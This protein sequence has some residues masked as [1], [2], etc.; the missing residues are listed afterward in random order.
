LRRPAALWH[1]YWCGGTTSRRASKLRKR[2]NPPV[3]S[4]AKCLGRSA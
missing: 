3:K 2:K 4:T 1:E